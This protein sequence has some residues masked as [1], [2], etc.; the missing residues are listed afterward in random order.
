LQ[1]DVSSCCIKGALRYHI[2]DHV[3]YKEE[4]TYVV[5]NKTYHMRDIGPED[6]ELCGLWHDVL[7]QM[8]GHLPDNYHSTEEREQVGVDMCC[9]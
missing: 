1:A 4:M 5:N 6:S 3:D 8:D 9:G 2:D 7:R